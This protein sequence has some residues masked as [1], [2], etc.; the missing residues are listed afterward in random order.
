VAKIRG[1]GGKILTIFEAGPK[2]KLHT[3]KN[4]KINKQP[5]ALAMCRI[6]RYNKVTF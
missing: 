1:R 5:V 3:R 4:E 6:K 2:I